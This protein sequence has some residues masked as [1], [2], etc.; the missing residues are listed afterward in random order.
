MARSDER[1]GSPLL[2]RKEAGEDEAVVEDEDDEDE[3]EAPRPF[4]RMAL[5]RRDTWRE[6]ITACVSSR[7]TFSM[8]P[9]L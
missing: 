6:F 5:V 9:D 8:R 3:A 1:N 4:F 7:I 2:R